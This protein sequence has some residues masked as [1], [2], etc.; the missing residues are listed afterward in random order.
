MSKEEKYWLVVTSFTSGVTLALGLQ[1][2]LI[3][4]NWGAPNSL[5]YAYLVAIGLICGAIAL[6]IC[7]MS[8]GVK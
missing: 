6:A 1:H 4:N 5:G 7:T 8:N 2:R 3:F